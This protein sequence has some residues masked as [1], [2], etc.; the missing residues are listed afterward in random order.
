MGG[1]GNPQQNKN[2][3]ENNGLRRKSLLDSSHLYNYSYKLGEK[4]ANWANQRHRVGKLD[5]SDEN[6]H[7]YMSC[8]AGKEGLAM[9]AIGLGAGFVKEADDLQ[10][11]LRSE[12][13]VKRYNGRWGIVKDSAKDMKNN[14]IGAGYG[15]F[16]KDPDCESLLKK[17]KW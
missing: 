16:S 5:V 4:T 15:L 12:E 17:K 11:K 6:K 10:R 9:T 14:F 3:S 1:I 2:L 8:L 7:Q 13:D